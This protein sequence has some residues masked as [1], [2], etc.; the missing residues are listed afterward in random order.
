MI[1]LFHGSFWLTI[2]QAVSSIS[3][4]LLAIAFANLLPKETFGVYKYVLSVAGVLGIAT[5]SGMNTAVTQAVARDYEGSLIPALK[6]RIRWGALAGL[7]SLVI[8]GYYY[9]Q[10]NTVLTI[11]F[12]IAAVFLPFM[13]SFSVYNSFLLGKKDFKTS[14]K[15]SVITQIIAI[16]SMIAAIFLTKNIFLIIL[17]YFFPW[18]LCRLFFLKITVKK[19][20]TNKNEDATTISYGKHL[21]LMGVMSM[22]AANFDRILVFH[23]LGAIQMA[24]YSIAIAPPEQMR[25]VLKN[26]SAVAFPKFAQKEKEE[27]KKTIGEKFYRL[28]F[29]LV[30]V[31]VFYVVVCPFLF[32]IFFPKYLDSVFYSQI[33][34]LSLPLALSIFPYSIFQA[35]A[36]KKELY[37][38]NLV[39]P[40]VQISVLFLMIYNFGLLGAVLG[41]IIAKFL[42]LVII[43]VILKKF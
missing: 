30:L 23:Y 22:I 10:G 31:A 13:D 34:A 39:S 41:G 37:F 27:I 25:G 21:S 26:I 36:A 17:A 1:Y 19:F 28:F 7:A 38:Y 29:I 6:A 3:S 42:N 11:S 4:F 9:F 2:S 24:V 14:G 8:A 5:L 43:L 12:L 33:A 18:T 35:Q 15:Y 20:Q 32:K 16:L 40:F